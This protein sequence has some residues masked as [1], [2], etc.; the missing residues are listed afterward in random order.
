MLKD[1]VLMWVIFNYILFRC[2]VISSIHAGFSKTFVCN[3][4]IG[5]YVIVVIPRRADYLAL[6]E[7]EVFGSP[8]Y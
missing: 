5:R 4:M 1:P 8:L 2:A 3:G 6:C 7:V